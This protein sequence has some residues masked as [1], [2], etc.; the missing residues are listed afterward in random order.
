MLAQFIGE[1][2][3]TESIQRSR[4]CAQHARFACKRN[5]CTIELLRKPSTPQNEVL[6]RHAGKKQRIVNRAK[7]LTSTIPV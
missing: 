5:A 2:R 6:E 1:I 7:E 3:L 4:L